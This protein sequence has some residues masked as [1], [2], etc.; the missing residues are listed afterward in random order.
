MP[1]V[2]D[3]DEELLAATADPEQ[4]GVRLQGIPQFHAEAWGVVVIFTPS[5]LY[6]PIKVDPAHRG[7]VSVKYSPK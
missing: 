5:Q 2:S 4:T 1:T 7:G 3:G 6:S